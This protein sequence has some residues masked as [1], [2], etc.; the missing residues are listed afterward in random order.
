M[1]K[2][3]FIA[4]RNSGFNT[5]QLWLSN[6][7]F[8]DGIYYG[9]VTNTPFYVSTINK[10]DSIAFNIDDITDWMYTSGENIIGGLSI[11]YLLEQMSE[12]S[13]EQQRIMEMFSYSH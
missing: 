7:R 1:V 8:K 4:D 10:G 12:H 13:I 5:E 3:P 6:I 2:Y 9:I 11:K